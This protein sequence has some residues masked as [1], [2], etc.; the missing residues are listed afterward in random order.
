ME[1]EAEPPRIAAMYIAIVENVACHAPTKSQPQQRDGVAYTE[2]PCRTLTSLDMLVKRHAATMANV[3]VYKCLH[4]MDEATL[5]RVYGE[6][7]IR[8]IEARCAKRRHSTDLYFVEG[9]LTAARAAAHVIYTACNA[10]MKR[11]AGVLER[12]SADGGQPAIVYP[13]TAFALVRPPGHHCGPSASNQSKRQ[14]LA[15]SGFCILN[16]TVLAINKLRSVLKRPELRV[17]IVDID[18]HFGDGTCA[19]FKDDPNVGFVSLH[20]RLFRDAKNN[21]VPTYPL[22]DICGTP[23]KY[24]GTPGAGTP[25]AG[26]EDDE[27]AQADHAWFSAAAY[28]SARPSVLPCMSL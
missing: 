6:P 5:L 15:S 7:A 16:G 21:V 9:T 19:H 22:E 12:A 25:A 14:P 13:H 10:V 27:G 23:F 18:Y 4:L 20:P 1:V 26:S 28:S 17:F 8:D 24:E 11:A 2:L 3:R